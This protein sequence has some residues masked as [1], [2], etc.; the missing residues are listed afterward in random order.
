MRKGDTITFTYDTLNRINTKTLPSPAPVVTYSYDLAGRPIGFTDT[1][2]AIIAP[3]PPSPGSALASVT[4][5]YD[6]LN[7]PLSFIFG[8]AVA[9]TTPP[10]S[11][12]SPFAYYYN[13]ANQR[14]SQSAGDNTWWSYPTTASTVNYTANSLNQ[15]TAVGAVSPT[16]DSN[17]NLNYDGTFSYG[18]DAENRLTSVTQSGTA[19]ATYAYDAQGRRKSKTVGATTTNYVVD[20]SNRALFDYDGSSGQ[21]QRWYAFGSGLNDAL[22]QANVAANTRTTFI[23]DVQGSIIGT[24]DSS[25]GAI[26]KTGYQ[27][28]GESGST[29]GRFQYTGARIDAETNGLY[30]FRARMYS[31]TL[32]RF[33]QP[34]PIGVLAGSNLYAYVGNDPLNNTDPNGACPQCLAG[35]AIGASIGLAFQAGS[36]LW[37][38][39]VSSFSSYVGAVVGGSV[40]GAAATVCGPACAG[41]TAGAASNLIASALNGTFSASGLVT[42]TA[43]GAAGGAVLGQVAPYV[44]RNYVSRGTKGAIG[45]GLTQL[46]LLLNRQ[47]IVQRNA[48][49]GVG[50]STFD[51]LL[52]NGSF[53]ESKFGTSDLSTVQRQAAAQPGMDLRVDYWNYPTVS[54]IGAA[55]VGAGAA[56]A[57]SGSDK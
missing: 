41:A 19:V 5:S 27:S 6:A 38:W 54:G 3:T 1:G 14:T 47:M 49:N 51:F 36:D 44:F 53:V 52:D 35:A 34:D 29:S 37:N 21:V 25:S 43:V 30:D 39:R 2:A 55:G 24:L 9:Q 31:P 17:G 23:P 33:L 8:P 48:A 10:A 50:R 15:Y 18:Y 12:S 26:A 45:E 4:M 46:D 28:F 42:D 7:Q 40:G 56:G 22:S 32:G 16:Y 13:A 20:P 57:P 11:G